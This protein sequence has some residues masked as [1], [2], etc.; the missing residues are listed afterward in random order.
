MFSF[1]SFTKFD[2]VFRTLSPRLPIL[3]ALVKAYITLLVLPL[4]FVDVESPFSKYG[5]VLSSMQCVV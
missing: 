4:A 3:A 5:S 1:L 2:L